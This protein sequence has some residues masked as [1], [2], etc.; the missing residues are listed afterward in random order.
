[1]GNWAGHRPATS[2]A[3]LALLTKASEGSESFS[4][5][6]R[7]LFVACEFW[8]A[9]RSGSLQRHL[10][11]EARIKLQEAEEAF[12]AIGLI[13]VES[14]LHLANIEMKAPSSSTAVERAAKEI[15]ER[16]AL[17]EEPVDEALESF[18]R[19]WV[20]HGSD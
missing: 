5:S 19:K 10:S 2:A 1:V 20:F 14:V 12:G 15:E 17:V 7:V 11:N 18:A 3:I 13:R 9:A 6:E 4:Y 8:A 16:V